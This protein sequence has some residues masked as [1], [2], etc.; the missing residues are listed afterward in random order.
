M[1][2]QNGVE[3]GQC[4]AVVDDLLRTAF[5]FGVATLN[6]IKVQSSRVG[7]RGHRAGRAT[8]HANAHARPPKLNQKGARWEFDFVRQTRVDGAQ[9]ARNHDGLEVTALDHIH[10]AVQRLLVLPEVTREVG[11]TKLVVKRCAA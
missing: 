3:L 10:I 7:A 5:N 9:A 6:G 2:G 4:P 11:S 8:P 1:N